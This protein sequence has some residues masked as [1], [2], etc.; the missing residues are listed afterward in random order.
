MVHRFLF[1]T[2]RRGCSFHF[3]PESTPFRSTNRGKSKSDFPD[4]ER[5]LR[6]QIV[7]RYVEKRGGDAAQYLRDRPGDVERYS[8]WCAEQYLG[9]RNI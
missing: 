7:K 6:G 4:S 5:K 8:A 2:T 9:G 3:R 1:Q